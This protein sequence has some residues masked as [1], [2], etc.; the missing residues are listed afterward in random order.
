MKF[1]LRTGLFALAYVFAFTALSSAQD[2]RNDLSLITV[3]GEA[4]IRVVP[5]EVILTLG[6]ETW[7]TDLNV[8]KQENDAK[9]NAVFETAK[10]FGIAPEHIQTDHISIEPRYGDQWEHRRFIGF[11]VRKSIAITLRET[12]KFEDLLSAALV[13]GTNYVHG[14]DFRTTQLRQHRDEAR[15]KAI[16]A[17][18]EKANALAK[19][20]GQTVGEPHMIQEGHIG[21]WSGYNSG[22]GRGWGSSMSQNVIQNVSGEGSG[23]N[24][25]ALGQ[26]KITANVTVSFEL[27]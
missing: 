24:T 25:I 4:E 26:I 7:N 13:A 19:E 1:K 9:V 5:D 17:A 15:S 23:G 8:A 11:F 6:V 16:K 20:L 21:W 18:Q 22:W 27:K 10:K 3:T 12:E 14:V 2:C